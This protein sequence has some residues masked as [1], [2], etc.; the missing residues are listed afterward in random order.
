MTTTARQSGGMARVKGA[1]VINAVKVL[2]ANRERARALLPPALHRY[3]DER[4]LPS[5]WY[6]FEDHIELLRTVAA[7]LGS[8]SPWVLMGRGTAR[9]DLSGIYKSHLRPGDAART[10]QAM[11]AMWRSAH[12]TG[13]L[14][15]TVDGAAHATARLRRFQPRSAE[16]CG[17]CTGYLVESVFMALKREPRVA[18]VECRMRGAT[19]CVWDVD[20]S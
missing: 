4:I 18:H 5:T 3:L 8:G 2:R 12:D 13:E 10:L 14:S 11:A 16:I 6:P 17:I 1:H 19:E 9:M 15:V 7:V 20:W